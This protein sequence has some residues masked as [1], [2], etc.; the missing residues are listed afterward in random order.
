MWCWRRLSR[1][2]WTKRRS[3]QSILKEIQPWIFIG[4]TEQ[5]LQNFGLL[6]QRADSLKKT[7]M[8]GKT[9]GRR[10]RGRQRMRWLDGHEFEQAPGDSHRQGNLVCCS[11]WVCKELDTT[12]WLKNNNKYKWKKAKHT[13]PRWHQ[14]QS[15]MLCVHRWLSATILDSSVLEHS[16]PTDC[17]PGQSCSRQRKT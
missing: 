9:E 10:R 1:V 15:K 3:N 4:R 2:S 13:V 14:H 11:S 16:I 12:E 17:S 5:K 6:I 7:L 8:L